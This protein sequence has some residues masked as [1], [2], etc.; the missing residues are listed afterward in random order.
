ME[1]TA[2]TSKC[3]PKCDFLKRNFAIEVGM[4]STGGDEMTSSIVPV[5]ALNIAVEPYTRFSTIRC[6]F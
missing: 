6:H 1:A 3:E 4:V 2:L 5:A